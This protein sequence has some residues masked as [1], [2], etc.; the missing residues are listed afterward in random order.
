MISHNNMPAIS[1]AIADKKCP[2]AA[3]VEQESLR[4]V[5]AS[6]GGGIGD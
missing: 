4:E 2:A 6:W 5:M 1:A 3:R